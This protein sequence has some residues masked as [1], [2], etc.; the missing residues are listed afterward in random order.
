MKK[1][2]T[3][4]GLI[5]LVTLIILSVPSAVSI[6][7]EWSWMD[8]GTQKAESWMSFWGG[9]LGAILGI[10]GAITATTIQ[11]KS[12][13]GQIV[14]AAEKN[15]ELER[16]RMQLTFIIEKNTQL[17][18]KILKIKHEYENYFYEVELQF[19]KEI[20]KYD[21]RYDKLGKVIRPKKI[22]TDEE[23]KILIESNLNGLNSYAV[24]I[25]E[26]QMLKEHINHLILEIR[27]T[28]A[29]EE[30]IFVDQSYS[31][32]GIKKIVVAEKER[33]HYIVNMFNTIDQDYTEHIYNLVGKIVQP[34]EEKENVNPNKS[35]E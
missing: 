13:T 6:L 19:E 16:K 2:F 21:S 7:M 26:N 11:I 31:F 10:V 20:E 24:F 29:N 35:D 34:S 15:D 4:I 33:Y 23:L 18:E 8:I 30:E 9:Y 1:T 17:Y 5:L 12:Q 3:I 28:I 27:A 32:K 25:L 22:K 14:M